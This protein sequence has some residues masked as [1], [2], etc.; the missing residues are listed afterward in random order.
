MWTNWW[1][2]Y[3]TV[4]IVWPLARTKI[5][6]NCAEKCL[7]ASA[8]LRTSPDSKCVPVLFFPGGG[9]KKRKVQRGFVTNSPVGYRGMFGRIMFD[10]DCIR[11]L[12]RYDI[13]IYI[14]YSCVGLNMYTHMHRHPRVD[15]ILY[16]W[17]N[18]ITKKGKPLIIFDHILCIHVSVHLC[19]CLCA[20]AFVRNGSLQHLFMCV[21]VSA[22]F[23]FGFSSV[24]VILVSTSFRIHVL[25][26][27]VDGSGDL[28]CKGSGWF[29][30]WRE[31]LLPRYLSFYG[32]IVSTTHH[33]HPFTAFW[34]LWQVED[35]FV[36]LLRLSSSN[37]SSTPNMSKKTS[38]INN[39]APKSASQ[40]WGATLECSALPWSH[41]GVLWCLDSH[42]A[43]L[44]Q[45]S[46]SNGHTGWWCLHSVGIHLIVSCGACN[47]FKWMTC[48]RFMM[49][50][51]CRFV[52]ASGRILIHDYDSVCFCYSTS[53][54]YSD[55]WPFPHTFA[56]V[57]ASAWLPLNKTWIA[58]RIAE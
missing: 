7:E 47:P 33:L 54:I 14:Y 8:F 31:G 15:Q 45:C 49:I 56:N 51:V 25:G 27:R 10:C 1:G 44:M 4:W 36:K 5:H 23:H 3:S 18:T 32:R 28:G 53:A 20:L 2:K 48:C 12:Y 26:F 6:R 37:S 40:G 30:Q 43:I 24:L 16:E 34:E 13:I 21:I 17:S 35:L 58:P 38:Q 29:V 50:Y 19:L 22:S 41:S 11:R 42:I 52:A 46:F 9:Q 39:N 55:C 57:W